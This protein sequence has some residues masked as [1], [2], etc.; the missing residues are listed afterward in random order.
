M[1]DLHDAD[2]NKSDFAVFNE[3]FW[4]NL[5]TSKENNLLFPMKKYCLAS[6]EKHD[7]YSLKVK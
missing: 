1:F 3:N 7:S 2:M 4:S 5:V 6:G